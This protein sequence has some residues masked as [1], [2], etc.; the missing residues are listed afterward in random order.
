MRF[1][2]KVNVMPLQELLDPQGKAMES[3]LRNQGYNTVSNVRMGKH[4]TLSIEADSEGEARRF[5]GDLC[6]KILSNPIME[7]FEFSVESVE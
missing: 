5:A 4:I 7:G 6:S 2:I 3:V 1:T